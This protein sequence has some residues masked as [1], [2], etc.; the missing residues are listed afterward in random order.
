VPLE[1]YS[2]WW[3]C[4]DPARLS[5]ARQPP[6]RCGRSSPSLSPESR[7]SSRSRSGSTASAALRAADRSSSTG[8]YGGC[9]LRGKT[10]HQRVA[11]TTSARALQ[12]Q[13]AGDTEQPQPRP[14]TR[15]N[16]I[17]LSPR[18]Q[19]G[20]GE[21]VSGVLGAR[22]AAH[23]VRKEIRSPDAAPAAV[24]SAD[25]GGCCTSAAAA[26]TPR[27]GTSSGS[28]RESLHAASIDRHSP[29]A[30]A[31]CRSGNLARRSPRLDVI[32]PYRAL[33]STGPSSCA[34]VSGSRRGKRQSHNRRKVKSA[35]RV[36]LPSGSVAP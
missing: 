14:L 32:T 30:A 8:V 28:R 5:E 1:P 27:A 34:E 25:R 31:A 19:V 33:P 35:R 26:A 22:G 11:R 3:Q 20:L 13:V 15:R 10:L 6:I 21:H 23:D 16:R 7:P 4:L 36:T 17:E 9:A 2:P 29:N 18:D 24:P 12:E